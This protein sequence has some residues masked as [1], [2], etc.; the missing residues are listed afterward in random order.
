MDRIKVM[1]ADDKPRYRSLIASL[2]PDAEAR[3][4]AE[5]EN[6]KQL[7]RKMW[8]RQPDILLLDLDM[9]EMDGNEAF[10]IIGRDFPAVKVII[11]SYYSDSTLMN[12]YLERG[13]K[14]YISKDLLDEEVMGRAIT[15]VM[16][17]NVF[18]AIDVT[19]K[20]VFTRR[21]Q[22][23][24]PLMFK[25]YTNEEIAEELKVTTRAIEKMRHKIYQR[26]GAARAVDFYRYAFGKGLQFLGKLRPMLVKQPKRNRA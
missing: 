9:P 21:Q 8:V 1:I 14:G 26:S 17:G 19:D 11:L 5:A 15:A 24:I 23:M 22:Q 20:M 7:I 25:G 16:K 4:I 10:E 12:H 2:L 13:A 3:V 6:G 18:T